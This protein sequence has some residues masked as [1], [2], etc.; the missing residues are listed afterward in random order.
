MVKVS[1]IINVKTTIKSIVMN[2]GINRVNRLKHNSPRLNVF[3]ISLLRL[4]LSRNP[5]AL[6][7]VFTDKNN[8]N[9]AMIGST[10]LLYKPMDLQCQALR[11]LPE[12]QFKHSQVANELIKH[13]WKET[14]Y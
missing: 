10:K 7:V 13:P 8:P 9:M 6:R 4:L 12:T 11:H 2:G 5:L 3:S 1:E 14:S